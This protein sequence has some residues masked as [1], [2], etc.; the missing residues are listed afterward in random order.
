MNPWDLVGRPIN[1]I[2]F[3]YETHGYGEGNGENPTVN[4]FFN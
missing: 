2:T 1:P 3:L 4:M